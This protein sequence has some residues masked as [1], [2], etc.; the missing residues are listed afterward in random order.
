MG[1]TLILNKISI[2]KNFYFAENLLDNRDAK[3]I[4]MTIL[5]FIF[6]FLNNSS[7]LLNYGC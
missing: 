6:Y 2:K 7:Q 5:K 1:K 4:L 3:K